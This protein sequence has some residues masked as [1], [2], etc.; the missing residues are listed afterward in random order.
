MTANNQIRLLWGITL[1]LLLLLLSSLACGIA[2]AQTP[3]NF[4]PTDDFNIPQQNGNIHFAVNGT[5]TQAKLENDVWGFTRLSLNNSQPVETFRVSAKD[6]DI[7]IVTCQTFNLVP[8]QTTTRG[9]SLTYRVNGR[10]TQTFNFGLN[11]TGGEWSVTFNGDFFGKN[12]GWTVSPD[13]TIT[14]TGAPSN[15]NVS[16]IRYR[17]PSSFG[18]ADASEQPFY[19]QHS[20]ALTTAVLVAAVTL[21]GAAVYRPWKKQPASRVAIG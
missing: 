4:T 6:S 13:Q 3:I 2:Q 12:E 21:L 10:G 15:S 17:L 1:L 14:V 16:I 7:T 20:V 18:N 9:A 11:L 19:Q 8:S 5:Y